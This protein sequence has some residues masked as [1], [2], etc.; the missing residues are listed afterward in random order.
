MNPFLIDAIGYLAVAASVFVYVSNTMVPLRIAAIVASTLFAIYYFFIGSWPEFAL[1]AFLVPVN[2]VRLVQI[3]RLITQMR[4]SAESDFDFD[5]LRPYMK[6]ITLAQGVTLHRVGDLAE[7]AYLLLR[8]D[9]SLT[10]P[11]VTLGPG[12]LFGEIG[13]FTNENRRTATAVALSQVELLSVRYDALL[14]LAAQN[15]QFSFYLMRLMVRRMQ[16]N[17]EVATAAKDEKEKQLGGKTCRS[18]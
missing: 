14:E 5:W 8:G 18:N 4:A 2:A 16:H 9:V 6:P 13:L 1:N 15:P 17:V 11:G 7:E 10:E 3:R 12:A